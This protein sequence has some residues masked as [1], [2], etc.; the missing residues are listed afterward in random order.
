MDEKRQQLIKE[1]IEVMAVMRRNMGAR[2]QRYSR[3]HLNPAQAELL[4]IIARH[5][6]LSIK[7]IAD[8]LKIT[9]SAVTQHVES[10]V[11]AGFVVREVDPKDRR[12]VRVKLSGE[13]AK[14]IK[15]FKEYHL[16]KFIE[17]LSPLSEEELKTFR[18]LNRKIIEHSMNLNKEAGGQE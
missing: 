16:Q 6:G 17:L 8:I 18:D 14:K 11:K 12:T 13:G 2:Q 7:E 10:L 1:I 9:G 4:H 15:M 3:R 5:E